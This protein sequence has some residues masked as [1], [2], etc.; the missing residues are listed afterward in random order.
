MPA[1]PKGSRSFAGRIA[2]A[3]L[4]PVLVLAAAE[5]GLRL[6]GYGGPASFF[7][8][9]EEPGFLRS[10]PGYASL[11]LPGG[12]DLR[13]L[14]IRVSERK[15]PNT[16]RVVVLGESAAQGVP[17]PAFGFAPLLRAQL[18]HMYPGR[19]IEVIDT[20]IVAVN[21]HVIYQIAREMARI[22]PDLFVVY[23][24]NNEVVGPYGPGCAY[25]SRMPPLWVIRAS[26][27]VRSTRLG[28]LVSSLATRMASGRRP[29]AEWGGM[30]MFVNS[31]VAGDDPRLGA[32]YRNFASN[33]EG[34]L[35]AA[36]GCGAKTVLCTVAANLKDCPP[37]LSLHRKGMGADEIARWKVQFDAGRLSWRLGES[38]KARAYLGEALRLDPQYADTLFMLGRL[39]LEAGETAAGRASLFEALHWDALRFRPD[40]R[41]NEAI[42]RAAREMPGTVLVDIAR[43]LGADPASSAP[44]A[45]RELLFEHVH[46]DWPGNVRVAG[47]M[48][49]GCGAAMGGAGALLSDDGCA[50]AVGYTEHERLPM[51]LRIEVLVRK[52]PFTGQLTHLEDEA[53]FAREIAEAGRAAAD[54]AVAA[55]ARAAVRAA[56]ASDPEN[57]ALE[58]IDEGI[59]LSLG[60][61]EGALAAAR[62]ASRLLPRDY[63]TEA[64]EASVLLRM[65]RD[66]E[67]G[68]ILGRADRVGADLDTLLPVL[69]AYWSRPSGKAEGSAFLARAE[70]AN[71]RDARLRTV[72]AAIQRLRGDIAGA[73]R[74]YRSALVIDPA[75]EDAL[76]GLVSLLAGANR[77][78]EAASASET[79][80]AF[81]PRNQA[82]DLRALRAAE[83]AGDGQAAIRY[84]A[85]AELAGP[86][87]STFELSLAL[88]LYKAGRTGE[89][90][91]RLALARELS[92]SEGDRAVTSS[93]DSLIARL[94]PPGPS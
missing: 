29:A 65:G 56:L 71:P 23:M 44:V 69:Q 42:R 54:P 4:A 51:L 22:Q 67:A 40:P 35:S 84:M 1:G 46:L 24:G 92:Q 82:N 3:I 62:R 11:F 8:P 81:Q 5:A 78:G 53:R 86:V 70:A 66:R 77:G 2:L 52:P 85:A 72:E 14:N 32:V 7:I 63:S 36:S 31:A 30:S 49:S 39:E 87:N 73:E 21:S 37:F 33:L 76:E 47:L 90:M 68:S 61:L 45:G 94:R 20:G 91:D 27:W 16:L 74:A 6:G 60:D 25:L 55:R 64:D 57:P 28:Q 80:E 50:A 9:D 75:N 10:N 18:R 79:F 93:I 58:G 17:V 15:A 19:R 83:S 26:V 48:A 59:D 34:I 41:I 13:P 89:M 88:K 12:F 38:G 43:E